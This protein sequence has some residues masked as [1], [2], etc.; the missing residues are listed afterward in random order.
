MFILNDIVIC[1]TCWW[2]FFIDTR[3]KYMFIVNLLS[4]TNCL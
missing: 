4:M 1:S 2:H 3:Y